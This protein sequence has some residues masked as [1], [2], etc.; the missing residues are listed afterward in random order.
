MR[1]RCRL[2]QYGFAAGQRARRF[3]R[4]VD[5]GLGAKPWAGI[6]LMGRHRGGGTVSAVRDGVGWRAVVGPVRFPLMVGSAVVRT[7]QHDAASRSV[8]WPAAGVMAVARVAELHGTLVVTA[9][10]AVCLAGRWMTAAGPVLLLDPAA[11]ATLTGVLA[12]G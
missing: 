8:W 1:A 12:S 6:W 9:G 4:A 10:A 7:Y 2:A 3:G 5:S 11:F